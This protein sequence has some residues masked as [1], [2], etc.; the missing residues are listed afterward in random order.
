M[1]S[2]NP[3]LKR[4]HKTTCLT[5]SYFS[6][7]GGPWSKIRN[8][9]VHRGR[10]DDFHVLQELIRGAPPR[11]KKG[12]ILW[13]VAQAQVPVGCLLIAGRGLSRCYKLAVQ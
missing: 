2:Q 3:S 1:F 5:I 8:P 11:L 10:L 12:G 6:F 7:V 4:Q 13:I 9:P